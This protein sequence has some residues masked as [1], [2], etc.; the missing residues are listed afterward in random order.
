MRWQRPLSARRPAA[1]LTLW[2][3]LPLL[4]ACARPASVP[5]QRDPLPASLTAPCWRGPAI[6]DGDVALGE[7]L[8]VLAEREAAAALCAV[9]HAALVQAVQAP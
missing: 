7:L 2:C 4:T 3:L 1:W 6:P 9:R 5:V 8:A